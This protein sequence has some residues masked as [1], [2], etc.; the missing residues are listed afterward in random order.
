MAGSYAI[1]QNVHT[2]PGCA[3]FFEPSRIDI[4]LLPLPTCFTRI[5]S[6]LKIRSWKVLNIFINMYIVR[7]GRLHKFIQFVFALSYLLVS[8]Q[9]VKSIQYDLVIRL[10]LECGYCMNSRSEVTLRWAIVMSFWIVNALFNHKWM[11][12]VCLLTLLWPL[13]SPTRK[14]LIWLTQ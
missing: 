12:L 13:L 9:W 6:S 14:F 1:F 11:C 4:F 5:S 7:G 3:L 8:Y 10:Y 2:Q